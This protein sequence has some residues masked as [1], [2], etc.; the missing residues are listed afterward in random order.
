MLR[1]WRN[2][3][4]GG[5]LLSIDYFTRLRYLKLRSLND[6][7]YSITSNHSAATSGATSTTTAAATLLHN[8]LTANHRNHLLTGSQSLK[9]FN[10]SSSWLNP[11]YQSASHL[12]KLN[13][14]YSSSAS[15]SSSLSKNEDQKRTDNQQDVDLHSIHVDPKDANFKVI[16]NEIDPDKSSKDGNANKGEKNDQIRKGDSQ[17][18]PDQDKVK[19]RGPFTRSQFTK[20]LGLAK[21]E[22]KPLLGGISL[23]GISSVITMSIPYSMGRIIDLVTSQS[24]DNTM[25]LNIGLGLSALFAVGSAANFGRVYLMRTSAERIIARVRRNLFQS[26][27]SQEI[28]FFDKNRTGEL[29]SR[30]SSDTTVVGKSLTSN[31][32]DGLR[33]LASGLV[34]SGMMLYISP[35][36]TLIMLSIIPPISLGAVFYGRYIKNLSR[37]TQD[38]LSNATKVAEER[39][40]NIRTIRAFAQE[41]NEVDRYS[42]EVNY[43]LQLA[44]KDALA[45]ATFYSGVGMGG[46]LMVI[47]VLL[48]GGSMVMSNAISIG[49]LT[50]FLLYTGFAGASVSGLSGFYSE[51]QKGIGATYRI[52]DLLDKKPTIPLEG[53][54][55]LSRLEGRIEFKNVDF[56][57]PNRN[58]I[59]VFKNFNLTVLPGTAV[60]VVGESGSGKSTVASLLLRY[61]DPLKGQI[62]IDG[63]DIQDLDPKWLRSQIGIVSQEPT[64]FAATIF[65]NIAYGKIN[66]TPE[67]VKRAAEKANAHKFIESFPQGYDTYVGE[68]GVA[69]SGGQKQRI[70]IARAILKNPKILILD[71]ATSALDSESEQLVQEALEGLMSGRTVI[72]IAHRLSTIKASNYIAV[73][74][75]GAIMEFDN[76]HNLLALDNGI[77]RR[78]MDRQIGAIKA[79]N[80]VLKDS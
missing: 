77:F 25:L 5:H 59:K 1:Y 63:V 78:L 52:F 49:E 73:L 23:L 35:K 62:A 26:I 60:A 43:V 80:N 46:N 45:S 40:A 54:Q 39:L 10:Y 13:R 48:I 61:Y 24:A 29:I 64:L 15:S 70:A 75:N 22:L 69:L 44:K 51:I 31:I 9:C 8:P 50:S 67:E 41:S 42:N 74:S 79:T 28:E 30:L 65:D 76:H 36:L 14:N 71:E 18:R 3:S 19:E 47:S 12:M 68:R 72:T 53:G 55:I 4:G 17:M 32:S 37:K 27:V 56:A 57:Y 7:F 6:S 20:L 11:S 2:G 21:P 16:A 33:S 58:E 34:G 66:A 38:A